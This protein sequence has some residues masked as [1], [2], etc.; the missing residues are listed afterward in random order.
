V[1]V[2]DTNVLA[3][4]VRPG[5]QT[6]AALQAKERDPDWVAPAFWRLEMRSVLALAM[7][8]EGMELET[9][10]EAFAAAAELVEDVEIE[11]S[12]E[13]SLRLTQQASI[14]AYDAEFALAAERLDVQFVTADRRLAQ[15]LPGRAVT[16]AEFASTP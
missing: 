3:Y 4:A 2:V 15:K 16:L 14:S 5:L 12:V 13:E 11:P 7:R 6:E 8:V 10:L 9:A 1:I